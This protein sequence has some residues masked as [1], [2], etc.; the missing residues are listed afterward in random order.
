MYT[1]TMKGSRYCYWTEYACEKT[2]MSTS[3]LLQMLWFLNELHRREGVYQA[4]GR[5]CAKVA[6]KEERINSSCP[7]QP[8]KKTARG[9]LSRTCSI[10]GFINRDDPLPSEGLVRITLTKNTWFKFLCPLA[11]DM[12]IGRPETTIHMRRIRNIFRELQ[13]TIVE[14]IS[15]LKY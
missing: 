14:A 12:L 5:L 2:S 7:W 6:I 15:N 3:Y 13:N 9:K 11:N 4:F 1:R 8:M 10:T